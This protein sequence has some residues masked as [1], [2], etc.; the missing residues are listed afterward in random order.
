MNAPST[1][2][3][4]SSHF[5]AFV[6]ISLLVHCLLLWMLL[7]GWLRFVLPH[8]PPPLPPAKSLKIIKMDP[9]PALDSKREPI[10]VPTDP[11]QQSSQIDRTTILESERNT[12]LKSH[13]RGTLDSPLPELS[14]N[15][16][17]GM[18]YKD[19]AASHEQKSLF[20]PPS[21]STTQSQQN[22]TDTPQQPKPLSQP[23][24]ASAPSPATPSLERSSEPEPNNPIDLPVLPPTVRPPQVLSQAQPELRPQTPSANTPTSAQPQTRPPAPPPSIDSV[25]LE[26]S[27]I[28]GSRNLSEGDASSSSRETEIG[29]YKAKVYRAIGSA[30]YIAVERNMAVLG[31]GEVKVRFYIRSNGMVEELSVVDR[32]GQSDPLENLSLGAIRKCLPFNVFSDTMKEQLGDGYWQELTFSIF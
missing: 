15:P 30:W 25:Q 4:K 8:A 7:H 2:F 16:K 32:S 17:S 1:I 14:G 26:H 11:S 28:D 24:A 19:S 5:T 10:F 13:E 3:E 22:P 12:M 31:V 21:P 20:S 18:V 6:A 27:R 29:A 23:S 9:P